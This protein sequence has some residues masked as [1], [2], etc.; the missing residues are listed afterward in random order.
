MINE[1]QPS[2]AS[3]L[4]HAVSRIDSAQGGVA[5][6]RECVCWAMQARELGGCSLFELG[7][8]RD[9]LPHYE[10]VIAGL[11]RC[12]D[13]A[14]SGLRDEAREVARALEPVI[15]HADFI[16][17]R[18]RLSVVSSIVDCI[19]ACDQQMSE[20][21]RQWIPKYEPP[22]LPYDDESLPFGPDWDEDLF[23]Q[24][25]YPAD[26]PNPL[27]PSTYL[28]HPLSLELRSAPPESMPDF[29]AAIEVALLAYALTPRMETLT[30]IAALQ[31]AQGYLAEAGATMAVSTVLALS[32]WDESE[33]YAELR[34]VASAAVSIQTVDAVVK[35]VNIA[36][37]KQAKAAG[38]RALSH[39]LAASGNDQGALAMLREAVDLVPGRPLKDIVA[40]TSQL[41]SPES[42][43]AARRLLDQ[44]LP[45]DEPHLVGPAFR[46]AVLEVC[47]VLLSAGQLR[48]ARE[49]LADL[50]GSM[51]S[52]Y[53]ADQS[54]DA[55]EATIRLLITAG[56]GHIAL[57]LCESAADPYLRFRG[58][59]AMCRASI[60]AQ[61]RKAARR[62][63]DRMALCVD[64]LDS[65]PEGLVGLSCHAEASFIRGVPKA[66][67]PVVQR[68][69]REVGRSR[70]ARL[71]DH[72]VLADDGRPL[73]GL[74]LRDRTE[75][76]DALLRIATLLAR[77]GRHDEAVALLL[78]VDTPL[79]LIRGLQ[80]VNAEQH[81]QGSELTALDIASKLVGYVG[82]PDAV[83]Y[84]EHDD[85]AEIAESLV[86]HME[87]LAKGLAP[88]ADRA[89]ST[90]FCQHDGD[91]LPILLGLIAQGQ[92]TT[93]GGLGCENTTYPA[94]CGVDFSVIWSR[95][96]MP[97]R[98]H[99]LTELAQQ[100]HASGEHEISQICA[101]MAW[102]KC[103][104]IVSD[105]R[106]RPRLQE[107]LGRMAICQASL[108]LLDSALD[109]VRW[110]DEGQVSALAGIARACTA[111]GDIAGLKRVLRCGTFHP[112][113]MIRVT[114]DIARRFPDE[115]FSIGQMLMQTYIH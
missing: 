77:N 72:G 106:R 74:A 14:D 113:F 4:L 75:V 101:D 43:K 9:L 104:S 84:A 6:A 103:C 111:A 52:R 91:W 7:S 97:G 57:E 21:I 49:L 76:E 90:C 5:L 15:R 24:A 69:S 80:S 82:T 59:L 61:D 20:Q 39:A 108:G 92:I 33:R 105:R 107:V 67:E 42:R 78:R 8:A 47:E 79:T 27:N 110:L 45:I 99:C 62:A 17:V 71:L 85:E 87:V 44:N 29:A 13:L 38:L 66:L 65:W 48:Q 3:S 115:A 86:V 53:L 60:M 98:V 89:S 88:T 63:T 23:E 37:D 83:V 46:D 96:S 19:G 64:Q 109:T 100:L 56:L 10:G 12:W 40:I 16:S 32:I 34:D 68:L 112:E 95:L 35:W 26:S 73:S 55:M 11:V 2:G 1:S 18:R 54:W 30:H 50:A 81:A 93:P 102:R 70:W 25:T 36:S 51:S 28:A 22:K 31:H 94:Q 41:T 58:L 114:G